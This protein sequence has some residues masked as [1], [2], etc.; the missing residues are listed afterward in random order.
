MLQVLERT[1]PDSGTGLSE[2]WA[3]HGTHDNSWALTT[4]AE[5]IDRAGPAGERHA[6]TISLSLDMRAAGRQI[7]TAVGGVRGASAVL[8]QEMSTLVAALRSADL[9]PSQWLTCGQIAVILR[10]AYDPGTAR[11]AWPVARDRGA[12]CGERVLDGSAH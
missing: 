4:Y 7:R 9:A 12:G 8:R 3:A 10:S 11:S 1:L 5:L 6:T 2:W